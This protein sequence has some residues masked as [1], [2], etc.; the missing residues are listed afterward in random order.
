MAEEF[1]KLMKEIKQRIYKGLGNTRSI[2]TKKFESTNSK[3]KPMKAKDNV[4]LKA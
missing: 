3:E 1:E 4:L 2:N